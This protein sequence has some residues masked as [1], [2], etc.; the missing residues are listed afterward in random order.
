MGRETIHV[1]KSDNSHIWQ[2]TFGSCG[3]SCVKS[4]VSDIWEESTHVSSDILYIY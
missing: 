2:A 4:D 3:V 1:A